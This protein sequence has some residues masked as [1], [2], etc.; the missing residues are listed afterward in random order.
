MGEAE[1]VVVMF[2][3]WG[4]K[5]SD[6]EDWK[7]R[8]PACRE[9]VSGSTSSTMYIP[10]I[11]RIRATLVGHR[12]RRRGVV[13]HFGHVA[14]LYKR[15]R[16]RT[17]PLFLSLPLLDLAYQLATSLPLGTPR[18]LP[19]T[20]RHSGRRISPRL[21]NGRHTSLSADSAR[22]SW[23]SQPQ[24]RPEPKCRHTC[25]TASTGPGTK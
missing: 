19:T 2:G 20:A 7:D 24:S 12:R 17:A 10:T 25:P 22:R 3:T 18:R 21:P 11:E 16:N 15:L 13:D 8:H 5:V 4:C 9:S 6:R 23:T 14:C 1:S